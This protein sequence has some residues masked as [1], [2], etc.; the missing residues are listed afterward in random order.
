MTLDEWDARIRPH[1]H[2][3]EAGAEMCSRH[4]KQLLYQPTF[5]T[6]AFD[7][8]EKLHQILSLAVKKVNAA[9]AAY[10]ALPSDD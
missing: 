6:I 9:K 8:L 7:D 1:L 3:I 2:G 4:V 5:E 10:R